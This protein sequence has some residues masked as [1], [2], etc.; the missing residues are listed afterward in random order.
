M[1][2]PS[3]ARCR[4]AFTLI[5]LLVVIAIIAILAAIL[6]PVFAKA[7]EKAR[8]SACLSN[9]KQIGT[10]I[11]MY[12]QDYDETL[13]PQETGI[14]GTTSSYGWADII[15]PYV[16][17]VGVFNC[18]SSSVQMTQNMAQTPPRFR[19]DRG[20]LTNITD[21][22]S[23]LTGEKIT[24]AAAQN[25]NYGVN[26][27]SPASGLKATN[28]GPFYTVID[29]S[30]GFTMPNGALASLEEP[31]GTAGIADGRGSSPW[32]IGGNSPTDFDSMDGQVD[33]RRHASI[34]IKEAGITTAGANVMFMDGHAKYTNV[35][36]SVKKPGNIWTVRTD[37]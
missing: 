20:G 7:R 24:D 30:G 32:S 25:Y 1:L 19:R 34:G 17:N 16:K 3:M 28:S 33:G 5:E 11:M 13:C 9:L 23:S 37:D 14:C 12:S 35:N 27:I 10:G 22:C 4:A 2:F 18:P 26:G 8:Q 31:A 29:S 21:D 6:F 36:Q 15:L